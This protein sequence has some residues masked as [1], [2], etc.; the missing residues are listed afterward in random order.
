MMN[1][2]ET[3]SSKINLGDDGIIRL[4]CI[5][6]LQSE[7]CVKENSNAIKKIAS[8]NSYPLLLD[9][10][11]FRE[12]DSKNLKYYESMFAIDSVFAVAVVFGNVLTNNMTDFLKNIIKYPG[13]PKRLFNEDSKAIEWLKN[14]YNKDF[15]LQQYLSQNNISII[16]SIDTK[17]SKILLAD[18]GIIRVICL[19]II[20]TE[21]NAKE[22]INA[23]NRIA[24][25]AKF[26]LLIDN[27]RVIEMTPESRKYYEA[28]EAVQSISA[29]AVV[30]GSK[31]SKMMSDFFIDF[32]KQSGPPKR[33]FNDESKA[34]HWLKNVFESSTGVQ[35]YASRNNISIL[36]M[37]ETNS[38]NVFMGD[39]GIVRILT[40]SEIHTA[41]DAREIITV[42]DKMVKGRKS[43]VL[44]DS[45]KVKDMTP[46]SRKYY[47]S[48]EAQISVA[49][50]AII[51]KSGISRFMANFFMDLHRMPGGPPRRLFNDENTALNWLKNYI[52]KTD[53]FDR[54]ITDQIN[55]L[56][57]EPISQ[58][59]KP[60]IY[61]FIN[62]GIKCLCIHEKKEIAGKLKTKKYN[63][64][65]CSCTPLT[66]DIIEIIRGIKQN[67]ELRFVKVILWAPPS[68]KD[69]F[70]E[71]IR[72]GIKGIILKPFVQEI[73][74]K[75][76]FKMLFQDNM[77]IERRQS[78]RVEPDASDRI[79][80]AIRSPSTHKTVVG[81]LKSISMD[82]MVIELTGDFTDEDLRINDVILNNNIKISINETDLSTNGI[83]LTRKQNIVLI[84]FVDMQEYYKNVLSSF[85]Y[86]K[87]NL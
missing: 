39:D 9:M 38:S 30:L 2:L 29:M 84:K 73:F 3:N 6:E 36:E 24:K 61:T 18:D 52:D 66:V 87:M 43:P 85:I 1:A 42:V 74:E 19:T 26:P 55:I 34:L 49:A 46:E 81:K 11:Q 27:S 23:V 80:I 47:E 75:N 77:N 22:N 44:I 51:I 32:S 58:I 14:F 60:I 13:P 76:I 54:Q 68:S 62:N 67:E 70:E 31:I 53:A 45:S 57:Y 48:E 28:D 41:D 25:D 59:Q 40:V 35:Q 79:L 8:G 5:K 83:I 71:M 15:D 64:F 16:E 65:L 4:T 37:V 78:I 56:V 63:V 21:D 20:Q 33:L 86:V 82:G 17:T 50:I 12:I 10:M 7:D 69:F 72:I